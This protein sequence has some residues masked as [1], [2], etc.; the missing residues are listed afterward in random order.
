MSIWSTFKE[1]KVH[2]AYAHSEAIPDRCG[3]A[4]DNEVWL[5]SAWF[6]FPLRLTIDNDRA[7]VHADVALT[8]SQVR[9]LAGAML[10]WADRDERGDIE[11]KDG[12]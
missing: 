5:S 7:R 10:E 4:D 3:C 8:R 12:A 6:G 11:M 2:D 9:E 1:L